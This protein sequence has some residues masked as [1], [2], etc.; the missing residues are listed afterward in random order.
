LFR[1]PGLWLIAPGP[2]KDFYGK[3]SLKAVPTCRDGFFYPACG[4]NTTFADTFLH[5]KITY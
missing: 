1:Q 3:Q 5:F 4:E 2:V